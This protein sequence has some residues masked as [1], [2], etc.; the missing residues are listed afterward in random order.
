[1]EFFFSFKRRHTRFDCD[2][3]SDVCSSDLAEVDMF[4]DVDVESCAVDPSDV[5]PDDQEALATRRREG[6]REDRLFD[7]DDGRSEERRVGKGTRICETTSTRTRKGTQ[8]ARMQ[9]RS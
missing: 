4:R 5:T 1:M 3:S 2:W 8:S 7:V 6:G 9:L